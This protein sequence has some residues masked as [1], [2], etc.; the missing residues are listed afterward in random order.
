M[1]GSI[2]PKPR[3]ENPRNDNL[4]KEIPRSDIPERVIPDESP[5]ETKGGMPSTAKLIVIIL[6][7]AAVVSYGMITFYAMPKLVTQSIFSTEINKLDGSVK[8]DISEL[9]ASFDSIKAQMSE[10]QG[11][12]VKQINAQNAA[13]DE[14]IAGI[15]LDAYAKAA[16]L[17]SELAALDSKYAK[18]ADVDTAISK[19][20]TNILATSLSDYAK[21]SDLSNYVSKTDY[22]ARIAELTDTIDDLE[23]RITVLEGGSSSDGETGTT[24]GTVVASYYNSPMGFKGFDTDDTITSNFGIKLVNNDAAKSLS[25][26][27]ITIKFTL[28][29]AS[30]FDAIALTSGNDTFNWAVRPGVGNVIICAAD[31]YVYV[32]NGGGEWS[33][34]QNLILSRSDGSSGTFTATVNSITIN[35]KTLQ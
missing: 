20:E 22:N 8:T 34:N 16:D 23:E 31:A 28:S 13:V 5:K 4:R 6:L 26:I 15:N 17:I 7:V 24:S 11:S 32:A 12:L 14:K 29:D 30:K 21:T 25:Y 10:L 2:E 19:F 18:P 35:S 3:N 27:S 33:E 1:M 9:T